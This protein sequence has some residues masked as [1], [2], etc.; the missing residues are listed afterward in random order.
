MHVVKILSGINPD[1]GSMRQPGL[2]GALYFHGDFPMLGRGHHNTSNAFNLLFYMKTLHIVFFFLLYIFIFPI[3]QGRKLD[4]Y[5]CKGR[6]AF[7]KYL[8]ALQIIKYIRI[9]TT[10]KL[11]TLCY[12]RGFILKYKQVCIIQ[13]M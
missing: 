8:N 2:N 4:I 5:S 13:C 6:N 12:Y 7:R 1:T 10:P 9:K 11:H 3:H